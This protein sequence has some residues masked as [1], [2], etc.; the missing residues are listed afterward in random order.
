MWQVWGRPAQFLGMERNSIL[1]RKVSLG[2]WRTEETE[3]RGNTHLPLQKKL[4]DW[5][6]QRLYEATLLSLSALAD[7][8]IYLFCSSA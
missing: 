3:P 4:T 1:E 8:Q 5:D 2:T 6:L 7:L